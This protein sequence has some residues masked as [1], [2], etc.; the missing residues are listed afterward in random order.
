VYTT[1]HDF[2]NSM[3]LC[4]GYTLRESNMSHVRMP[5]YMKIMYRYNNIL[6]KVHMEPN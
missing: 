4:I 1:A 6:Q 3:Y 5:F 2:A